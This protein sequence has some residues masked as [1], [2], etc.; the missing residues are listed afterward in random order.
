MSFYP[1]Y[2]QQYDALS[3]EHKDAL[4]RIPH[5]EDIEGWLLLQEAAELFLL[6]SNI[7]SPRPVICEIGVWKGKS[8]YILATAIKNREG[9][10]YSID[11]FDG[12]G[13]SASRD[14]YQK[15]MEAMPISLLENFQETL[16]RYDLS[17]TVRILSY[18]SSEARKKFDET[19]IDMLFIDGNHDYASVL[20]DYTLWSDKLVSGGTLVLHDVGAKHVDGPK[21]VMEECISVNTKWRNVRMVGEMGV[22]VKN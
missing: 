9:I 8:S 5:L 16:K 7:S 10:L 3:P 2:Q 6:A 21:R 1:S 18:P 13:D 20:E 4:K 14:S 11:P 22:A 19:A 15:E 12:D 17:E